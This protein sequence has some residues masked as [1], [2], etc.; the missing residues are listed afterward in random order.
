MS[1]SEKEC[2]DGLRK[3]EAKLG[4]SPTI[5]EYNDADFVP[6]S[7]ST[8]VE[9]FGSWNEAKKQAGLSQNRQ[10]SQIEPKPEDVNIPD[11]KSWS[12]L[13]P[14]QR[15]YYKNR[16]EEKSRT[17]ERTKK[18][19]K[20]FKSYKSN[21]ECEKCGE[22]HRACLDFHH[23]ENKE[24]SVTDLVSRKNTSKKRIKEEIEKCIVLCA[25]CHRKEHHE[26]AN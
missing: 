20:W 5:R 16:E 14:Y 19:K 25:N 8:I 6:S 15:Y 10:N 22:D 4:H 21:F 17:K 7:A 26:H 12:Q 13:S 23:T 1:Y 24:A 2:L 11:D 3:A 18:L 9:K